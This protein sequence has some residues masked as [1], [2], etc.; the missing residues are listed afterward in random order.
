MLRE[1]VFAD[2]VGQSVVQMTNLLSTGIGGICCAIV[3]VA[4]NSSIA[5]ANRFFGFIFYD[6]VNNDFLAIR[7]LLCKS[8]YFVMI[9]KAFVPIYSAF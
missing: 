9:S 1:I 6:F 8:K 4:P 7:I 5:T 3:G 2:V